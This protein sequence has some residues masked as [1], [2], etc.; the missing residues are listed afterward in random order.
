MIPEVVEARG[1]IEALRSG[2]PSRRAVAQ[3]GTTQQEIKARFDAAL[4]SIGA[5]QGAKPLVL[6]ANFGAGKSHL[7]EYLQSLAEREQFVTSYVVVSPE[8]PLGNPHVVLKEIAESAI[9]PGRVGK[10]LHAL[11]SDLREN[12]PPYADLRLW[13]REAGIN[14]RFCALL[15]LYEEFRLDPELQ[16]QILDDFEGKPLK[17]TLIK[18]K[19]K[20]IGELSGYDLSSPRNALLAHDRIRL[21]AQVYRACTGKGL[22]VFFDEV[23]RIAKFSLNQ[24]IAA[25]QELA[26][27]DEIA[28][29]EGSAILPVFAMTEN[30][31][32][33][34]LMGDRSDTSKFFS[35]V[36]G[37][38]QEERDQ[39][40]LR[41]IELLKTNCFL[42][43]P[44]PEQEEEIKYRIKTI[45]EQAYGVTLPTLPQERLDV[46]TT[47]RSE[48]RR[49][50]TLWDLYR[51]DPEYASVIKEETVNFDTEEITD[52]ALPVGDEDDNLP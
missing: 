42:E 10:A 21:L 7:L 51:Y 37:F 31:L 32:H 16:T 35:T 19:L 38:A 34:F 6:T 40:A 26:W 13:A 36:L 49:W 9:A 43:S 47:V 39:S 48:I 22:V 8:M 33:E 18:Q 15:H 3:L 28:G 17:K 30:F 20:E 23:E 14:E 45:Y 41:G 5:R 46:R 50:I 52:E 2:V 29:Q 24:R 27:W 11:A 44:T 1:A 4:A 25:Y 12:S